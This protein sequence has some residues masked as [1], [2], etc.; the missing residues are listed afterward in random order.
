MVF[1]GSVD[2]AVLDLGEVLDVHHDRVMLI[3]WGGCADIFLA[4]PRDDLDPL[5]PRR[6]A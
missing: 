6:P 1:I 2:D 5:V 4:G 3:Q